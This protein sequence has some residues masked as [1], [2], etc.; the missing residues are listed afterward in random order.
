MGSLTPHPCRQRHPN[1]S[2]GLGV[3]GSSNSPLLYR[4]RY[5]IAL[6][7]KEHQARGRWG[8]ASEPKV[9]VAALIEKKSGLL[10]RGLG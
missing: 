5:N 2:P 3:G 10:Q 6:N 1:C 9:D 7:L 8:K 4:Q